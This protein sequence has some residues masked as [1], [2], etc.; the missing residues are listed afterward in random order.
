MNLR[1]ILQ[2]LSLAA[3][4]LALPT[5]A[6][7]GVA[8]TST[9]MLAATPTSTPKPIP[10]DK[11]GMSATAMD[12]M[13]Y[14]TPCV[15]KILGKDRSDEIFFAKTNPNLTDAEMRLIQRCD[16]MAGGAAPE[17]DQRGPDL[18]QQRGPDLD[19]QCIEE[20][21]GKNRSDEII[22][23]KT[24]PN[25]TD[26]EMRLM[27]KCGWQYP[28]GSPPSPSGTGE[29]PKTDGSG[30]FVTQTVTPPKENIDSR[31]Q[32][33][34]ELATEVCP[35]GYP[36]LAETMEFA[37][38]PNPMQ[39]G[40]VANIVFSPSNPEIVYLGMEVNAHSLYKSSDGGR[41][42]DRIHTFD[43]AKDLAVHPNNPDIVFL[44]DSH[45]VWKTTTGGEGRSR[46]EFL[47]DSALEVVLTSPYGYGPSVT[48]F[49]TI[50]I[51]P[52]DPS[53]VY[54]AMKG[55][56]RQLQT[57][58]LYR[59][60]NEGSSFSKVDG[61]VPTFN[62]VKV[63][64]RDPNVVLAGSGD[65][66]YRSI[67]GGQSF[68]I[69][70]PVQDVV[71]LDT[72]DGIN[73]LAGS[74]EGVLRSEDGGVNWRIH[75]NGL[76]STTVLR[77]RIAPSSPDVVW[78]TTAEGV[79]RSLDGGRTW[80]TVSGNLPARNLQALAVHPN[81]ARIALVA[82]ETFI[83]SVRSDNLFRQGQYYAQGIYRTDDGGATWTR[84]DEGIIEDSISE[85]TAHPTRPF[86]V[87]AGQNA[88]R[89]IYRSRDASQTWSLSPGFLTHYPMRIA[90][91]PN[92]ASK[93]IMTGSHTGEDL[94]ITRDSGVNWSVTSEKMILE[95]IK[96]GPE[97]FIN[98]VQG[99][100]VHLHGLA[101]DPS[102]PQT[103]YIGSI[104][105]PATFSQKPLSGSHI[106][107]SRDAG[108]TWNEIGVNYPRH[109]ET[110][111][112][113]IKVDPQ[114]SKI[115]YLGTSAMESVQGN[116]VWKSADGGETWDQL[117]SGIP[118]DASVNAIVIHPAEPNRILVATE[119]GVYRSLDQGLNWK[120]VGNLQLAMDMEYDPGNP[121]VVYV[122]SRQGVMVSKDFGSTWKNVSADLPDGDITAI[123]VN[124]NGTVVYAGV[125][126]E[127]LFAAVAN[128]VSPVPLDTTTEVEYGSSGR[129][130]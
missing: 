23:A 11:V 85:I 80:Q 74:A 61:E 79:A 42:W 124:C 49:S 31:S 46:K 104:H 75:T 87:W 43:H 33:P 16:K 1:S 126:N 51:A 70:T 120:L 17:Q 63:D 82:T 101:I 88:S 5:C 58:Q 98:E 78:A 52:S 24:D 102:D 119:T 106:F 65:G 29:R 83:F 111:I 55:G 12:D 19:Q 123:A 57:G 127:G 97:Q 54:V 96:F 72:V 67:D 7:G 60:A 89:G 9:P 27:E 28:A 95:S 71:S 90:F 59:S 62:V 108:L 48:S 40:D 14:D 3:L 107:K 2:L 45:A 53:V 118:K 20:S 109:V 32:L 69:L 103:I 10:T 26:A 47:S 38:K 22:F 77:V 15:D 21:L 128:S 115:V 112:R 94:G 116:G 34:P 76:P 66:V 91:F 4:I 129:S 86:E 117:V 44:N 125:R 114:N 99:G 6:G 113:E 36:S 105:D 84:S 41:K 68:T 50:D 25:L 92:D 13:R 56:G 130:R 30:P 122:A 18:D 35:V 73:I 64:P 8:P 37:W 81:D 121:D 110:S 93:A 39:S 100:D